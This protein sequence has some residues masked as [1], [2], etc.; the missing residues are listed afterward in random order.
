[1]P[2][3]PRVRLADRTIELHSLRSQPDLYT[4]WFQRARAETRHGLC[5]CSTPAL[6]LVIRQRKGRYHLAVWP[7]EGP[8][9]QAQC[10]FHAPARPEHSGR[11]SYTDQAIS[12]TTTGTCIRLEHALATR[13]A[14]TETATPGKR[15]GTREGRSRRRVGLLGM[16]HYLWESTGLTYWQ[17]GPARSWAHCHRRVKISTAT[18]VLNRLPLQEVLH[19]VAPFT[20]EQADHN[21]AAFAAWREP[22]QGRRGLLLGEIKHISPTQYGVKIAL[23]HLRHP[24]FARQQLIDRSRR[25]YRSAFTEYPGARQVALALVEQTS[26]GNLVVQDLAVML[27]NHSYL[28]ADSTHEVV[29]AD[30]LI[31]ARRPFYKPVR[32]DHTAA[33][34]PDFVL[35]DTDPHTCVEVL[36]MLGNA[37]YDSR[38]KIKQDHYANLGTPLV[39]WDVDQP[40]PDLSTA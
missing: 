10:P 19:T 27:T 21:E 18:T 33:V 26:R 39:W 7:G 40:L 15:S 25:S 29:M 16:L 4:R 2:P 34:L 32:Y 9:H 12:H 36:G 30:H 8:D 5:L 17:P 14:S 35:T 1:M 24:L 23:R 13:G 6:R 22:L 31:S 28:P 37:D 38:W 3:T 11:T 20:R